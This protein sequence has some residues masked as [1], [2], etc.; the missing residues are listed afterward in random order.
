MNTTLTRREFLKVSAAVGGGLALEFSVAGARPCRRARPAGAPEVTALARDPPRRARRDPHR[1]LRDGAGQPHRPRA[2]R[3]RGARVRLAQGLA[4]SSPRPTSTCAASAS[5]A[6]CPPAAA[7]ASAR[8]QEYL[9]KSGAAA[10]EMLVA[11]AAAQWKVPPGECRCGPR[12]DHPRSHEAHDRASAR[13][14]PRASQ[15]EV[16]EGPE[17]EG[18]AGLD[19]RRPLGARASTFPTRCSASPSSAST[20]SLPGMLTASIV[21]SPVFLG[22]VK[23]VDSAAAEKMRGVKGV[24]KR[25]RLRRRGR[26]QL[27]ARERGREARSR[28]NGTRAPCGNA[29]DATIMASFREGLD[30]KDLPRARARRRCRR[31]ARRG[32]EGG[33]GR[34][35]LALPEPRDAW[36][37]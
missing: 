10:R 20:W 24:V 19:D 15:L 4:P 5:G 9:R 36:S 23:S 8:S 14:R 27:V 25:R 6:R 1:P 22:K 3:G 34:V 18:S 30:A 13:S 26:R 11:A 7:P 28:S 12:R 29:S 21:Q 33:R 32:R 16:P 2:A 35:R 37:R 31:G 17:A